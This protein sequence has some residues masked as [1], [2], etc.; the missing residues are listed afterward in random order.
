MLVR[1]KDYN[2]Y[3]RGIYIAINLNHNN[4]YIIEGWR[5]VHKALLIEC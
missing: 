1:F 2:K 4:E 5:R 3:D